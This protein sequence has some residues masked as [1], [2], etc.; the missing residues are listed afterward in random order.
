VRTKHKGSKYEGKV[1]ELL[2][3][4]AELWSQFKELRQPY[5]TVNELFEDC[6]R[7]LLGFQPKHQ[8]LLE[9]FKVVVPSLAS[10]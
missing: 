4:D 1:T 8:A 10:E 7:I 2:A 3:L 6:I 9:R 5:G